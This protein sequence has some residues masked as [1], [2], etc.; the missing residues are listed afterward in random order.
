MTGVN[1]NRKV[2]ITTERE[3]GVRYNHTTAPS[4]ILTAR[5]N[6]I[7]KNEYRHPMTS[8]DEVTGWEMINYCSKSV[9]CSAPKCPLDSFINRRV[10]VPEDPKCEMARATRHAYWESMPVELKTRLPYE[11]YFKAEFYRIKN[12]KQRWA[13][14]SEERKAEIRERMR[15]LTRHGVG[16]HE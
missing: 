5:A 1:K 10:E 7:K 16:K 9:T 12:G 13:N 6:R 15:S 14:L 4:S 11:G 8:E 2:N 3:P